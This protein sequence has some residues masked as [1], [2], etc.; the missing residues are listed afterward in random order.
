MK[1]LC[2]VQAPRWA[3]QVLH[4]EVA[5]GCG[6][7]MVLRRTSR[8]E[9][10]VYLRV[11]TGD[12]FSVYAQIRCKKNTTVLLVLPWLNFC[13]KRLNV[14]CG[15][16]YHSRSSLRGASCVLKRVH[17]SPQ[18]TLY[19]PLRHSWGRCISSLRSLVGQSQAGGTCCSSSW[20]TDEVVFR[21][22]KAQNKTTMTSTN[23]F[24][25][26]ETGSK[27]S[28]RWRICCSLKAGYF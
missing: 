18:Q 8:A 3:K 22:L 7:F 14:D 27:P 11:A 12:M 17:L 2:S 20:Q 21:N 25:G 4:I 28:S 15:L 26:L 13:V 10:C 6:C 16:Q 24:Q 5:Y 19:I 1:I 9:I 23:M